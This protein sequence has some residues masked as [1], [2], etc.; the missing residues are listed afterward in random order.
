MNSSPERAEL[1]SSLAT[2]SIG[3]GDAVQVTL[4]NVSSAA[5]AQLMAEGEP[6]GLTTAEYETELTKHGYNEV[7]TKEPSI[8]VQLLSRYVG[9]V[10]LFIATT[11]TLSAAIDSECIKDDL[12]WKL[13]RSSSV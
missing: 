11:A 13:A 7:K 10:P 1:G 6:E 3:Q 4:P 12:K 5:A 8:F 2:G 9:I